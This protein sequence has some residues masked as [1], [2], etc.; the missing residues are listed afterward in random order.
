MNILEISLNLNTDFE[1]MYV[2][3]YI[4][5]EGPNA[6]YF[7]MQL[8]DYIKFRHN[9]MTVINKFTNF[10]HTYTLTKYFRIYHNNT[11]LVFE[12]S[13]V[14]SNS[15]TEILNYNVFEVYENIY[16]IETSKFIKKFSEF[17]N[18]INTPQRLSAEIVLVFYNRVTTPYLSTFL[19][20][21][22]RVP[23]SD[24]V[25]TITYFDIGSENTINMTFE[26][27]NEGMSWYL[28]IFIAIFVG[29]SSYFL[30]KLLKREKPLNVMYSDEVITL[31]NAL[32]IDKY[33]KF[34]VESFDE[35]LKISENLNKNILFHNK[36][37]VILVEN[38]AYYYEV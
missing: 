26:T 32:N 22:Y 6:P 24:E 30:F 3:N 10:E 1:V 11:Q 36:K 37:Y 5:E 27:I 7:L 19:T 25:F 20:R 33:K 31:K 35:L 34:E 12:E 38:N 2:N 4:F 14:I 13:E 21:T 16:K 9:F 8:T 23:I 18:Y 17:E 15:Y 29:I 28:Y